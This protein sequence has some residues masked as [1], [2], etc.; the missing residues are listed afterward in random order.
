MLQSNISIGAIVRLQNLNELDVHVVLDHSCAMIISP[1][2]V[3][4]SQNARRH[5][6]NI[7]SF[8]PSLHVGKQR[9]FIQEMHCFICK[10]R[11]GL[12]RVLLLTTNVLL[13]TR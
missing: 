10:I 7:V 3:S 2:K 12:R 9:S 4:Q 6:I 5:Q 11:S 8:Q 1:R 13:T